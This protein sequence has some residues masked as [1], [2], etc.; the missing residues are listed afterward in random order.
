MDLNEARDRLLL[1]TLPHV[2]F[3]GWSNRALR[4]AATDLG[5]DPT[6]PERLFPGGPVQMVDHFNDYADRRMVA[7]LDALPLAEMRLTG[8]VRAAVRARLE[9]WSADREAVRRALTL[10]ALPQNASVAVRATWRTV[11]TIWWTVGDSS[12]DFSY[13]TSA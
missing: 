9:P 1:A 12:T 3:E 6:M 5:M 4:E 2:P 7:E 10:L 13:Y 8:K 11:D